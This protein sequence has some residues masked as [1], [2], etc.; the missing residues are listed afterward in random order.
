MKVV[1]ISCARYAD[2]WKP[3]FYFF[4]HYYADYAVRP[5]L[6]TDDGATEEW[7]TINDG[8]VSRFAAQGDWCN[9]LRTYVGSQKPE[10]AILLI[11]EDMW[12][13]RSVDK[14]KIAHAISQMRAM[15]AG[16]VRLYPCPGA[17][18]EYGDPYVGAVRY[19]TL[20]RVS[21]QPAI[22]T[23]GYLLKVLRGVSGTAADFE[24]HGTKVAEKLEEPVLAWKRDAEPWP[25]EIICSAVSRGKWSRDAKKLCDDH[26]ILV[27][28]E[29][30]GFEA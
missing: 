22:W 28:W 16:C 17:D 2:C 19:G 30:R 20:Y 26:G 25:L 24:I 4:Q 27:D 21:C 5:V 6:V 14:E 3:F 7:A 9:I 12:L 23:A 8:R 10:E 13:T 15:G 11:Q 29:K 18:T 1:V